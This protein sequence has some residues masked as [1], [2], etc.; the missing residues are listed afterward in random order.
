MKAVGAW[1]STE[2]T[3]SITGCCEGMDCGGVLHVSMLDDKLEEVEL[4]ERRRQMEE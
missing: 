2:S 3:F 4:R 1:R